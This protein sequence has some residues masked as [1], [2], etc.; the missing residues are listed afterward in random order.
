[1]AQFFQIHPLNPQP[2]L[3][4]RAVEIV[5]AGG[6]I[7][8][9]TDSSYALGCRMDEKAALD[10]IRRIRQLSEDHNFT[11][12]CED[13]SQ[14]AI[15]AKI[16]NEAFRMMKQ[17]TPGPYTFILKATREVPRR[18]QHP[19]RKSIGIRLPDNVISKALVAELAEPMFSA[20]LILPGEE[21][22]MTDPEDI[23][24]RLEKEVDLIIDA[25]AVAYAPT[26]IIGFMEETPEII[27][28]GAG[29]VSN[30]R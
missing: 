7:V 25:G 22:A 23:R 15:F 18:L 5:K 4:R 27:R 17:L 14:I 13:L 3:I 28:Q 6:V 12:V 16:G 10:R 1:M 8:Y 20:T 9:P 11:L 24:E 2:R 26:T 30:L 21:D 19:K 29:A